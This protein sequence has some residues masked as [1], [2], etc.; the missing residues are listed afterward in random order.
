MEITEYVLCSLETDPLITLRKMKARD[1]VEFISKPRFGDQTLSTAKN[2]LAYNLEFAS[3]MRFPLIFVKTR[4]EGK[5]V[6]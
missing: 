3:L 6:S 5:I 1:Q 2:C 4:A